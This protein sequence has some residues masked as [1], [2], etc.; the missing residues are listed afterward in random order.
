MGVLEGT[1][2]QSPVL[3]LTSSE[4]LMSLSPSTLLC[5]VG[6]AT[7]SIPEVCDED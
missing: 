7:L 5:K 1:L 6:T 3:L 4:T 2:L